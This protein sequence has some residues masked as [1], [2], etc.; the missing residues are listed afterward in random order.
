MEAR[1]LGYR[2]I[3]ARV[4]GGICTTVT[5]PTLGVPVMTLQRRPRMP[6]VSPTELRIGRPSHVHAIPVVDPRVEP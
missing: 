6:K 2:V 4:A 1:L 5:S 3:F